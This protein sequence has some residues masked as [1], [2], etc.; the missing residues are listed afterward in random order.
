[1]SAADTH[2][3]VEGEQTMLA[4]NLFVAMILAAASAGSAAFL[5]YSLGAVIL[6]Y[7][8]GGT[9]ALLLALIA[10]AVLVGSQA[11]SD[12]ISPMG[13]RSRNTVGS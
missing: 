9:I 8:L 13:G 11:K 5:G 10:A 6:A 4:G 2:P 7:M 3:L 12:A 1:M